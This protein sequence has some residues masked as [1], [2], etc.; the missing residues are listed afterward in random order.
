MAS[1]EAV[2]EEEEETVHT[3]RKFPKLVQKCE[4]HFRI[5]NQQY[6]DSIL[7]SPIKKLFFG[8]VEP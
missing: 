2:E 7:T 8:C 4:A 6:Q 3:Y 1:K 5:T